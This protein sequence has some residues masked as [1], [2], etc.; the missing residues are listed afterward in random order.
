MVSLN[1]FKSLRLS[2]FFLAIFLVSWG[3]L[4]NDRVAAR[5]QIQT[6][7]CP[8]DLKTLTPLLLKS[9]PSYANRVIQRTQR[10]DGQQ[11][12]KNYIITAGQAEFEPLNLPQIQYS[13]TNSPAPEQIF[14]TVLERQYLNQK[15]VQV[16]TYHWLF[17][18]QAPSGWHMVM[19][20]S[21]FGNSQ[22]NSIPTP[23]KESSNGI[24]GQGVQLWLK[25]C[26]A[27]TIRVN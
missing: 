10:L 27:G 24:I 12:V 11:G 15:I 9:L 1:F 21:R 20:F 8:A 7:N 25:D 4:L 6:N 14:F 18:T 17:L 22:E 19:M 2:I 16:E 3:K 26:R 23:P 13:S 5:E